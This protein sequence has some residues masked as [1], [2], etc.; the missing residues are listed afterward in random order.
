M[1][2]YIAGG[3]TG[4]P[5]NN[6]AAFS[7]AWNFFHRHGVEATSPH[8]LESAIE[9]ETRARMGTAAVYR[10]VLPTDCFA[11]SSVDAVVALPGWEESRGANF[12]KHFADLIEIP[13]IT[14]DENAIALSTYLGGCLDQL[15]EHALASHTH[16]P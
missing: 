5:D 12:E 7:E 13:W 16:S 6:R 1:R 9:V 3:M 15:K 8:F 2:I 11:I 14:G 4:K 10:H